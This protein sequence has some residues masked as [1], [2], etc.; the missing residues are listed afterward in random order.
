MFLSLQHE[1]GMQCYAPEY[2][3]QQLLSSLMMNPSL[4][5]IN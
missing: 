2:L 4:R 1:P 5:W 3:L